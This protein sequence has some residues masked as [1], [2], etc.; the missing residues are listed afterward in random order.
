MLYSV[1]FRAINTDQCD[2]TVGP[3]TWFWDG[4]DTSTIIS[5]LQAYT[6]YEVVVV[7]NNSVGYSESRASGVTYIAG[8]LVSLKMDIT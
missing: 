5:G 2:N 6:T 8:K 4:T 3:I 1:Q 7:A